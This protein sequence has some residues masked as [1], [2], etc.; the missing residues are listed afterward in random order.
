M[1]EVVRCCTAQR[2]NEIERGRVDL[3]PRTSSRNDPKNTWENMAK[4]RIQNPLIEKNHGSEAIKNDHKL[5]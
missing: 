3:V 4:H 2:G 5:S 1:V